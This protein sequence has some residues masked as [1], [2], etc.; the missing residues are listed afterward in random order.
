[1]SRTIK[2]E[3]QGNKEITNSPI[4]RPIASSTPIAPAIQILAT[5]TQTQTQD[6][7]DSIQLT[8][9]NNNQNPDNDNTDTKPSTNN[10]QPSTSTANNM[11]PPTN[12]RSQRMEQ[13]LGYKEQGLIRITIHRSGAF[14]TKE[15]L[16]VCKKLGV[17]D[18][19]KSVNNDNIV[20]ALAKTG[21]LTNIETDTENMNAT[22]DIHEDAFPTFDQSTQTYSYL[23]GGTSEKHTQ[24]TAEDIRNTYHTFNTTE[25]RPFNIPQLTLNQNPYDITIEKPKEIYFN[26]NAF[27]NFTNTTIPESI[28]IVLSFGPKFC[29]PVYYKEEDFTHLKEAAYMVNEAFAHQMDIGSI[30]ND[31]EEHI[32]T[33]KEEQFNQYGTEIRDYFTAAIGETKHFFKTHQNIIATQSDKANAALIM[34]KT[35]YIDKIEQLLSD[36]STYTQL[37]MSSNPAYQIINQRLLERMKDKGWIKEQ[38]MDEAIRT[39]TK[40]ANIYALIKTHK[41]GNA[42]RPIVNTRNSPGYTAAKIISDIITNKCR[43]KMRYNVLNSR[44]AIKRLKETRLL[45]DLKTRSYDARSMFT[46]ISTEIALRAIFKRQ[47]QLGVNIEGMKLILDVIKFICQTHTEIE[48]NGQCYKQI[49][50]LRM[51]SSLSPILADLV[52][53]DLLDKV[54]TKIQ[55]PQFFIKYVDDICTLT[56][57]EE[58]EVIYK[59]L[60]EI[61]ENLKFDYEEE[62]KEGMLNYLDFTIVR[63]PFNIKTKWYQKHIASGRFL[64]YHSHHTKSVIW[65]TAVQFVVTMISNSNNEYLTE[66]IDKA[67]YLLNIN[68]YPEEYAEKIILTAQEKLFITNMQTDTENPT[69]LTEI[70][71]IYVTGIPF[72]PSLTKPIQKAIE[73]SALRPDDPE[74]E[75]YAKNIKIASQPIHK[76]ATEVFNKYKRFHQGKEIPTINLEGEDN[77]QQPSKKKKKA[78]KEQQCQTQ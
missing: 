78:T 40:I 43:D 27:K 30:R 55:R 47:E 15:M 50:G 17:T 46:N 18:V 51:G 45:P 66:M 28:A 6:N 53:E 41:A 67:R 2:K 21:S 22:T 23:M 59:R 36:K 56:T 9:N 16:L 19:L 71:P 1:M 32:K 69:Q 48:F 14:N 13:A 52:M 61:D 49:K 20:V 3:A 72:I 39:E 4:E 54:F 38:K 37:K 70:E 26:T 76:V 60:N 64:N 35:I 24:V 33:Y 31:I 7:N 74:I 75:H 57:D 63:Q 62:N 34:D 65:H 12:T 5:N 68:S 58:H 42:P 8:I 77:N 25:T 44:A 29:L 73:N 10:N 11:P